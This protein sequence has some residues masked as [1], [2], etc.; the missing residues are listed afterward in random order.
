MTIY[1]AN[2]NLPGI[3]TENLA[4]AQNAAIATAA[5]M[6]RNG[7][8]IRYIRS[9]FVPGSGRCMCLFEATSPESVRQL[10]DTARIPYESIVEAYDL[11]P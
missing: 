8:D 9:T 1:M 6:C 10:N 4:A 2:R 7:D 11:T 5:E 3:S